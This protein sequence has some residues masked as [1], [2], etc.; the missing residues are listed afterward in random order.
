MPPTPELRTRREEPASCRRA[1]TI[2]KA[3]EQRAEQRFV[4]VAVVRPAP[5]RARAAVKPFQLARRRANPGRRLPQ[6]VGGREH[7][8]VG[9]RR[10]ARDSRP[11]PL[12]EDGAHGG[13]SRA[14]ARREQHPR[15]ARVERQAVHRLAL[16]RQ[17]PTRHRAEPLEESHPGADALGRRRL[18]PLELH[19]VSAPREHVERAAPRGRRARSLAHGRAANGLARPRA[20]ARDRAPSDPR[21][22]LVAPP[23]PPGSARAPA[24]RAR[25]RG[26][27]AGPCAGPS[28]SRPSR[29]RR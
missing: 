22:P 28:R 12:T 26:R 6:A 5:V 4:L 13:R 7:V 17:P 23:S 25:A 21:A 16:R 29:P 1:H 20:A 3:G 10:V 14:A 2:G 19:D 24:G 8:G 15:E 11:P 18:E 27:S 9:R